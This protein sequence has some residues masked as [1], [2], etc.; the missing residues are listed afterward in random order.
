MAVRCH[1]LQLPLIL[2]FARL[3]LSKKKFF[4]LV[5]PEFTSPS[6]FP[7][8]GL[9][10]TTVWRGVPIAITDFH[11]VCH[12]LFIFAFPFSLFHFDSLYHPSCSDFRIGAFTQQE[13]NLNP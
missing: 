6:V 7:V 11:F 3:L 2:P 10:A 8:D 13:I 9:G 4:F 1:R 5:P 12:L